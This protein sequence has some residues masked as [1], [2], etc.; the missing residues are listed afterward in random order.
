MPQSMTYFKFPKT[1]IPSLGMNKHI[2]ALKEDTSI[3][4]IDLNFSLMLKEEYSATRNGDENANK[5]FNWRCK[6]D[7]VHNKRSAEIA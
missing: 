7:Y 4:R 1:K 2:L 6:G 3:I 5:N